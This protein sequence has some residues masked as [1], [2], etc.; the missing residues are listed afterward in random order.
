MF[1]CAMF[2]GEA[3][4]L[5]NVKQ[6]AKDN[7]SRLRNHPSIAI[8]W[9]K[10]PFSDYYKKIGRFMSEY[11]F[12]SF[13]ELKMV[14]YYTIPADWNIYSDV[15]KAHQRSSIGNVTIEKYMLRD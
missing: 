15:M 7:I 13:P 14:K 1:V 5:E 3:A 8:W 10:D 4:F 2:P 6:E 9:A 11:G 12:Q